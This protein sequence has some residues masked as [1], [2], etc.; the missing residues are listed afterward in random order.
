VG[1]KEKNS[2]AFLGLQLQSKWTNHKGIKLKAASKRPL[3]AMESISI[4]YKGSVSLSAYEKHR[5]FEICC[6]VEVSGGG[7]CISGQ[8]YV[9]VTGGCG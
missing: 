4:G 1:E 3:E 8:H 9:H 6:G 2:K 5:T 7:S